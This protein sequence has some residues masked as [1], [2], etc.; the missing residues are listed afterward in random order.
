MTTGRTHYTMYFGLLVALLVA[1]LPTLSVFACGADPT[2]FL[3]NSSLGDLHSRAAGFLQG[4]QSVPWPRRPQL[5]LPNNGVPRVLR[6]CFADAVTRSA[7][8]CKVEAALANWAN[9][10]GHDNHPS[11]HSLAWTE[12]GDTGQST[13]PRYCYLEDYLSH[14]NPGTWCVSSAYRLRVRPALTQC[15]YYSGTTQLNS[16]PLPFISLLMGLP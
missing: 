4:G 9:A 8:Y 12:T 7:L 13:S 16:T 14:H 15:V 2:T 11:G 10:L 6:F 5:T 3:H 1:W